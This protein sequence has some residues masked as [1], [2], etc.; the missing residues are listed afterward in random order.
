[1]QRFSGQA[2]KAARVSLGKSRE[3]VAVDISRSAET[4]TSYELGRA[5]PGSAILPLYAQ[6]LQ[7]RVGDLFVDEPDLTPASA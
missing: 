7:V 4:V 3:Q 1:M 5:L 6:S 2:A